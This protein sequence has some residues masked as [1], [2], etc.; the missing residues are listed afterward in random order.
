[1]ITNIQDDFGF[2]QIATMC[3]RWSSLSNSVNQQVIVLSVLL[4]NQKI[5]IKYDYPL[6]NSNFCN[7]INLKKGK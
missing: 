2:R 5:K 6:F 1:M 7:E 3:F 4:K